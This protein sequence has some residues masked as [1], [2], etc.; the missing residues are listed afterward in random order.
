[1]NRT[2]DYFYL[3]LNQVVWEH[4]PDVLDQGMHLLGL[5]IFVEFEHNYW[6]SFSPGWVLDP[7]FNPVI[8]LLPELITLW[9]VLICPV[10]ARFALFRHGRQA[11]R[12]G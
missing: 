9:I 4:E 6:L 3:C 1:M 12:S 5:Y 8:V 7:L 11:R 10:M 2:I